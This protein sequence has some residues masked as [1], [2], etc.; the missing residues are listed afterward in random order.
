MDTKRKLGKKVKDDVVP[1]KLT[2]PP[3]APSHPQIDEEL[4][5]SIEKFVQELTKQQIVAN[6]DFDALESPVD[7]P[8]V[9]I[10]DPVACRPGCLR[11]LPDPVSRRDTPESEVAKR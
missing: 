8:D 3:V 10:E 6:K 9:V 7:S 1:P 5:K 2:T 4:A 11:V